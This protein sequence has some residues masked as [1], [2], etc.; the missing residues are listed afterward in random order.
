MEF[1][2]YIVRNE[3]SRMRKHIKAHYFMLIHGVLEFWAVINGED[4]R[5]ASFKIDEITH[6]DDHIGVMYE[7]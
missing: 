7:D 6:L 2:R 4:K 3:F 1:R 5:I